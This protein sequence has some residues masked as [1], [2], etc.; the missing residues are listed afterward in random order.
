MVV[1]SERRVKLYDTN[2]T[3]PDQHI[4]AAVG[5]TRMWG[6]QHTRASFYT[7]LLA[8]EQLVELRLID[9]VSGLDII[10]ST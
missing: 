1:M 3:N 10:R 6:K 5:P 8:A 2:T 9:P 7:L 4:A